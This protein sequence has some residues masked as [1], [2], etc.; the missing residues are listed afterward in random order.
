ML[1]RQIQRH[2]CLPSKR[3]NHR[4]RIVKFRVKITQHITLE[5][6]LALVSYEDYRRNLG[7]KIDPIICPANFLK[8]IHLLFLLFKFLLSSSLFTTSAIEQKGSGQ[9]SNF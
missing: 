5:A 6:I 4:L 8:H 1:R 7:R 3:V 2:N 9:F